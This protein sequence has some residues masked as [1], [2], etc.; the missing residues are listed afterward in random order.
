NFPKAEA[1]AQQAIEMHHQYRGSNHIQIGW[2]LCAKGRALKGQRKNIEAVH[3]FE[4]ALTIFC[5]Q[6]R[7]GHKSVDSAIRELVGA[8]EAES[9]PRIIAGLLPEMETWQ[10][11]TFANDPLAAVDLLVDLVRILE[12]RG[13]QAEAATVS[14]MVNETALKFPKTEF[15]KNPGIFS[16]WA[17]YL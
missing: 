1:L 12:N 6:H 2:A 10:K 17:S 3:C 8:L 15:L 5:K 13:L 11:G 9:D 7:S 4:W 14:R 16:R